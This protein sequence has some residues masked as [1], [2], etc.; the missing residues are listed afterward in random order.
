MERTRTPRELCEWVDLKAA[1]LCMTDEGKQFS[2]SG[3]MLPKK[4]WEEVRPFG[5]FALATYGQR[6]GVKC[7][8]NLESDNYDGLI[9]FDDQSTPSVHVEVTYAKDGYD[10]SLRLEVLGAEG[11]VNWLGTITASGTKAAGDRTISVQ[12]EFIEHETTRNSSLKIVRERIAGKSGKRYG[13]NHVLVIVV[14]DYLAFR[15]MEDQKILEEQARSTVASKELDFKAVYLLGA[16]GKYIS[17][18]RGQI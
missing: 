17:A 14:D 2:R 6:I 1:E 11:S 4:L 15:T 12:S 3:A 9:E 8:P 18:I 16:S 13:Q 7:T 5:L 10:E